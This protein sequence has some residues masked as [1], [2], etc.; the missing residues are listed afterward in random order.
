MGMTKDAALHYQ[1]QQVMTASP[2]QLVTMLFDRAMRALKDAM[3]AIEAGEIEQRYHH[4][5]KA[6]D[7]ISHL[8][9][10]L[11][12]ERGG[13]IAQNLAQLYEFMIRRLG[14]VDLH[15]DPKPAQEVIALMEPLADSWRQ[16]AAQGTPMPT[17]APAAQESA[18][19]AQQAKPPAPQPQTP[20]AAPTAEQK[21]VQVLLTA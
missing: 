13:E 2:A 14:N 10:T 12:M 5:S 7:I 19:Q 9:N 4:N 11:D 16:L 17:A 1:T 6:I 21:T 3:R 20:A 15:N 8:W 18:Q